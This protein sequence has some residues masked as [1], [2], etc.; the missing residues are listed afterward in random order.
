[1]NITL[2]CVG[3][4]SEHFVAE[5]IRLYADRIV[6]YAKF[7]IGEID[8]GK[9]DTFQIKKKEGE[10]ILKRVGAKDVCILLDEKG[11]EHSS[12]DFSKLILGYQNSSVKKLIF[13]IGG[14]YGFSPEVYE[15]ANLKVALSKMTFPHQ[16]IRVIFLEQL[17]RA[18]TILK[19]EKYHH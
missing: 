8:S 14:A 10:S 2:L 11:K 12:V 1:M 18:Y 16:L 15:R 17:Y 19:G 9:G 7:S 4:T 13:I 6:R 5:G 3:K